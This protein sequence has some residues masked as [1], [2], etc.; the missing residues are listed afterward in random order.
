MQSKNAWSID[1]QT[2]RTQ[3]VNDYNRWDFAANPVHNAAPISHYWQ[4]QKE[5]Y[6]SQ[7]MACCQNG[8][9]KRVEDDD[10]EKMTLL[11]KM[12]LVS[13][14]EFSTNV[15]HPILSL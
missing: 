3:V 14:F 1:S 2:F 12:D 4:E 6:K 8:Q 15:D 10:N 7:L 11:E 5:S 9:S 13:L